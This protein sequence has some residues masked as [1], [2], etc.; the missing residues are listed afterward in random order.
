MV[1]FP[2]C[3]INLGLNVTS[4][5]ADNYHNIET[6]FYPIDWCDALEI[7]PAN[8]IQ[9][10]LSP[11]N[12]VEFSCT[13]L[14]VPGNPSDNIC[15]KAYSLLNKDFP[16]L[17]PS[18][19]IHLHKTIPTGA[20][21]G[22][23][24]SNGAFTLL[25]INNIF[26]L[27]LTTEQLHQYAFNLGSDCPFFIHNTPCFATG[28]GEQ[29]EP[30]PLDLSPFSFLIVYP[31]IHIRTAWA[32]AQLQPSPSCKPVKDIV[33]QPVISWKDELLNDFEVPIFQ[34]Y[35]QIKEIKNTLYTNGALYASLSGSGSSVYGIF[36]K[37]KVPQLKWN[38]NYIQKVIL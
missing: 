18:S 11:L 9:P 2:N 38:N 19:S 16:A 22:G 33:T 28:R 15:L 26:N 27:N 17:L 29:H 36:H 4:K 12:P 30:L 10:T 23:G 25:L 1:L 8:K 21:L 13:G 6:V 37:N 20:G 34:E 3:K 5:R 14:T 35:P 24:S 31:G 7:L 32:F